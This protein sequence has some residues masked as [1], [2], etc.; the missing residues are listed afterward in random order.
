M[1]PKSKQTAILLLLMNGQ[2]TECIVMASHIMLKPEF[3]RIHMDKQENHKSIDYKKIVRAWDSFLV[4][5][6]I[7]ETLTAEELLLMKEE[8]GIFRQGLS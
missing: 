1:R 5:H 3:G 8:Y 2:R 4:M 7:W 6:Y